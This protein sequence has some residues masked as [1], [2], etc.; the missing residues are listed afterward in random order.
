MSE[1]FTTNF[2]GEQWRQWQQHLAPFI[3]KECRGLEIGSWEG[4]SAI[5]FL[6]TVL[7]HSASRLVCVDTWRA[8]SGGLPL[9]TD[10]TLLDRFFSNL[11]PERL[12][13]VEAIRA[14][15]SEAL[16]KLVAAGVRF[17]WFYVDGSHRCADVLRDSVAC[18][19]L[20]NPGAVIIW[21]D[22]GWMVE[23]NDRPGPAIDA[24]LSCFAGR[25]EVLQK[26]Y[27]VIVRVVK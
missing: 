9:F 20:A 22:H 26:A 17:D 4:R 16:P 2:V 10:D 1:N 27:Q 8:G 11:G 19:D 5:W 13:R 6:D 15:S 12:A 24:F 3:G 23:P 25:Y 18:W 21:D 7:T 14:E